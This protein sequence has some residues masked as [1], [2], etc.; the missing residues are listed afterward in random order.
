MILVTGAAGFIGSKL[1][2]ILLNK[3]HKVFGVDVFY[4]NYAKWIKKFNLRNCVG[5]PNFIFLENNILDPNV[6]KLIEGLNI[7]CIV[8]L[9]DIPGVTTC[10]EIN[11]D[12]YIKYNIII[13]QRL[14]ESI[15]N[16]GVKKLIY[17]S[18]S[19]VYGDNVGLPMSEVINPKPISL[20]GVTKLAG[21]T[22]SQYYGHAYGIEVSI[23]RFFTTYGPNQRPD[24]AFHKFI[25]DIIGGKTIDV[26]GD[27]TQ[28]RDF[29][30]ID[31][32]CDIITNS[33]EHN[34]YDEV[35]NVGGGEALSVNDSIKL[36]EK[37]LNKKAKVKYVEP[38]IEE[39]IITHACIKKLDK[40][41]IKERINIE[42]G[43]KNQIKYIRKLY[44]LYN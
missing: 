17:A 12:E 44:S 4:N 13:T 42:K 16:K 7:N 3:G 9:A 33:I 11:F 2:E 34:I 22:L 23:L 38:N 30:Y 10:S 29:I 40:I 20:Y 43:L 35:I 32:V 24:M 14:L 27:G 21:E 28:K 26:Y 19:T 37:L 36:I 8:H 25:R 18:S 41:I 15:K 6:I 5:N 39:Q 31:D 1:C